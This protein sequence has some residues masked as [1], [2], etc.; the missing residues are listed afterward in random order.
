[1]TMQSLD[2]FSK[3]F[4]AALLAAAGLVAAATAHADPG[5]N[6]SAASAAA[7]REPPRQ[8]TDIDAVLAKL[9]FPMGTKFL[10]TDKGLVVL[11]HPKPV[12]QVESD[13]PPPN[14]GN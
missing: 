10:L 2:E 4:G 7:L 11:N 13:W 8:C 9:Q 14:T 5:A 1:M 3:R 12:R 6:S